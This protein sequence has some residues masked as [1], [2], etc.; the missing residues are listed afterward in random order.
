MNFGGVEDFGQVL[1][2]KSGG[3]TWPRGENPEVML[4]VQVDMTELKANRWRYWT[5][6]DLLESAWTL[7]ENGEGGGM[8]VAGG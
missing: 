4:A 6:S 8:C 2:D 1:A 5:M 7:L 3:E